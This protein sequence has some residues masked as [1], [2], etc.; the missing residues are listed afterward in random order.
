MKNLISIF[1]LNYKDIW[2][3]VSLAVRLKKGENVGKNLNGKSLGLIFEKPSTRTSVSFSVAIHQLGAFPLMLDAQN[4]QRKRGETI[5]DTAQTLSRYLDGVVIRAFR[6]EDVLEFAAS[7]GIPTI[8]GLTDLEH[9]CQILGDILTIVEKKNISAPAGLGRVKV[10][11]IGDGNNVANS[12]L[13]ACAL[14]GINFSLAAPKGYE[15]NDEILKKSKQAAKQSGSQIVITSDPRKAVVDAD[16]IYTDVWTSMGEESQYQKRL[17]V[18]K[19]YQV[20]SKLVEGAKKDCLI[21]HCLPAHRGEEITA[22]V[23]DGEHSVIFDQAENRLHIQKAI[24]LHLL[25]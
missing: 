16:V 25:G 5:E 8:S 14:M 2:S 24:L 3:I 1:D 4:M 13:A 17:K 15:P 18:F 10:A 6:H 12:L 23:I 7:S 9:P 20:N 11:F 19:N 21:M 22:D